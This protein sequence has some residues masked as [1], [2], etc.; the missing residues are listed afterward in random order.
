MY[1][2]STVARS[3]EQEAEYIRNKGFDDQYY[4][5]MIVQYLKQYGQATR[6]KIRELLIDKLPE[7][8]KDQQKEQKI[9]NLLTTLRK[10]GVIMVIGRD[11]RQPIWGL[12]NT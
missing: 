7:S 11:G 4:K 3:A 10:Q 12:V 6:S 8:L 2:S 5:D 1:I 9:G